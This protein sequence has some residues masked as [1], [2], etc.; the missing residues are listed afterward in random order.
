MDIRYK[1][2]GRT[3]GKLAKSMDNIA[4]CFKSQRQYEDALNV[5]L[6]SLEIKRKSHARDAELASALDNIGNCLM[7]L[8]RRQEAERYLQE[9]QQMRQR[10]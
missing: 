4:L 5:Y 2:Y 3:H 8:T 9:A 10:V 7:S 1:I 6:N